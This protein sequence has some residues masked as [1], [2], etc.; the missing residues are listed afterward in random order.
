MNELTALSTN[1][2]RVLSGEQE[3]KVQAS[4]D[5][6]SVLL[7]ALFLFLACTAG[8]IVGNLITK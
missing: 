4:V 8:T 5:T 6:T 3:L 1:V 7:I 2:N